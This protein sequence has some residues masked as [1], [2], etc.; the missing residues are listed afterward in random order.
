METK[1]NQA[2]VPNS[3][4]QVAETTPARGRLIMASNRGPLQHYM[5][6]SGQL[7]QRY[8]A[9]GVAT[10]L[11]SL[12]TGTPLTWISN[13]ATKEDRAL[14][15]QGRAVDFGGSKRLLQ[16]AASYEANQLFYGS[17]CNPVLWF[18]QHS[19]WDR[20]QTPPSTNDLVHA[21]EDGYLAVN[22]KFAQA[23]VEEIDRSPVP[24]RVL[25]HD[26]HLY[27]APLMVRRQRPNALLQHFVH[28]PW[29]EPHAWRCL[30][31]SIVSSICE[32]LLA[33]DSVAFQTERSAEAFLLTCQAFLPDVTVET[34]SHNIV[35]DGHR[36]SVWANPVSVDIW[37]LRSLLAS[38]EAETY[39]A[40]MSADSER[41]TIVRVDRLD[42]SK[43]VTAGFQA[44]GRL[45]EK[46]PEWSGKV[47]F[48][49]YLVPSRTAIPEY[50]AYAQE[51][52]AEIKA[53]NDRHGTSDWQPINAFYEQNRTQALVALSM[54]DVL[55]V[56]PLID[57]MNLVSKEGPVLNER[58]GVLVLSEEA[59]SFAELSRGA[60]A[61]HPED[62]EGTA[63]ALHAALSMPGAERRQRSRR[64][65]EAV[66]RHDLSRWLRQL[67]EDVG[68]CSE[69]AP[70]G[71]TPSDRFLDQT[72]SSTRIANS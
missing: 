12:P 45:L 8:T 42:P 15:Q 47:T 68:D 35:S 64:L 31:N 26:Y 53:V 17:F 27:A 21:W 16:V 4:T 46:H 51:V 65:R 29:P 28:I 9:G 34:S 14:A 19:L 39:R 2:H 23:V 37:D 32:G 3:A 22:R 33:N 54:Y 55:L 52:F 60:L 36:T 5:D 11:A 7:Q 69:R 20:L 67:L 70:A 59:G 48:N 1:L 6:D 66:V 43:N 61:V 18:L 40:Q 30:P 62:V 44:Y 38:P 13:A 25:F 24:A 71:Q 58:D 57:G 50:R 63:D 49:A 10:A 41:R 72:A 56:N